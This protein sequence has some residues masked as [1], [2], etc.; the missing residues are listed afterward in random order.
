[1]RSACTNGHRVAAALLEHAALISPPGRHEWVHA[2]QNELEH[3]PQGSTAVSWA[4]GC[5]LVSY[6]ERIL[7]VMGSLNN[8]SRW[9]LSIEMAVC[10]VPLTWLFIAVFVMTAHGIMPLQFG[11]LAGSGALLGP[12]GL[13]VGLRIIFAS[14]SR[15]GKT[16]TTVMALLAAWTVVAY[17]GQIVQ[18]GTPFTEVWREF[19]LIAVLPTLAVTHLLRINAARRAAAAIA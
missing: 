10:L 6:R 14:R 8:V 3:L 15:L 2:M 12:I 5:V 4:L 16:T 18:N 9:L 1:M 17:S 7:V 13:L 11:I 19:V